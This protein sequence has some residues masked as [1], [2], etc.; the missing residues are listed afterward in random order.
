LFQSLEAE[1]EAELE[2]RRRQYAHYRD[3]LLDFTERGGSGG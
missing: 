1:L 3:S 2:A